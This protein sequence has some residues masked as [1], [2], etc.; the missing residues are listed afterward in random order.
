MNYPSRAILYATLVTVL[1]A[2][3]SNDDGDSTGGVVGGGLPLIATDGTVEA[4][5]RFTTGGVP[6]IRGE[7]FASVAFGAGYVQASD[8]VCLIAESIVKVRGER[9]L[10]FGPGENNANI[11]S[12]FSYR[13]ITAPPGGA[14][15]VELTPASE[16]LIDGFAAGY[17]QYLRETDS[18]ELPPACRDQPW[19]REITREDLVAYYTSVAK[20]ASGDL[21]VTGAIYAA[22]PPGSSAQATVVVDESSSA[23]LSSWQNINLKEAVSLRLPKETGLASNA[24]GIGAELSEGGRG[25]LLANP[26]FPYSG[27]RRLYQMHLSVPGHYDVNGATLTGV[28]LPL[29]GFNESVAWSHTV[30][31]GTRF[32]WYE[33][34]LA[35]GD[36]RAYVKDGETIPFTART[37]QIAVANGSDTPTLLEREFLFSEYGPMLA[38]DLITNGALPAWGVNGT[39]YTYRDANDDVS[40]MIDSWL[41]MGMSQNLDDFQQVF[42][43]CGSTLWT[44]T[45]Y[46]DADGNAWYIDSSSVPHL[47]DEALAVI[48][49]KRTASADYAQLFDNGI[50][51]L[52]GS[53]SRDDWVEGDCLG[54]VPYDKKPALARRDFVQNSNS[55]HWQS[56]PAEQLTGFSALYGDESLPVNERTQLG[57]RMLQNPDEPGFAATA[58]AGQDSLFGAG[59]LLDVIWNNRG[60]YA[61][62]GLPE[63][64][65]RCVLIADTPVPN[66]S[67]TARSVSEGCAV[68]AGWDGL[69]NIDS[70]G[71]H[72]YRVFLA[73]LFNSDAVE[74]DVQFDPADP[75]NTQYLLPT[76]G[77]GTAEDIA[78]QLLADALDTLD[79]A[80]I[81]YD[82]ALG[83]V[84]T[85]TPSGGV[86]PAGL[87]GGQAAVALADPIPWHGGI[88][89]NEGV[90]NAIGVVRSPVHEDTIYPRINN[91]T[92]PASEGLS[93]TS[94]EGWAIGRG[95][96]WHFGLEFTDEGPLAYG[97]LSYSQSTD[98][99]SAHFIDQSLDYSMKTRRQLLYSEADI[100]ANLLPDTELVLSGT[101]EGE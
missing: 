19:V 11:L 13:I 2:C 76:E 32:T 16:A 87:L 9:S 72:V 23:S 18:G 1:S 57:L 88:G 77:R 86:P 24:W 71:A 55:S 15:S 43:A 22:V 12:D 70:V 66:S 61:E 14:Q 46:A 33:L 10:F 89:S 44:N 85:W 63:L 58:P 90:F 67:N 3:S 8:N 73:K 7:D 52:D 96:S 97:L 54:R 45:V 62:L 91:P 34:T 42:K 100:A 99:G 101:V 53:T 75:A 95:T 31:T 37:I 68:L 25:A 6:H 59:E 78:L 74:I 48:D 69:Y 26:H 84:Q 47:S 56:N 38:A 65:E 40:A 51:L 36:E 79:A 35:E 5:I 29:I 41:G 50:T 80:G 94:G 30:S 92:L 39:A 60:L 17:N 83:T 28:P 82:A 64:R 4:S 20:Y 98:P 81:A 21:F 49:A 93:A 27:P